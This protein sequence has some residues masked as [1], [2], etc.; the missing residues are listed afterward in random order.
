MQSVPANKLVFRNG[1][2]FAGKKKKN[3]LHRFAKQSPLNKNGK[4]NKR[5]GRVIRHASLHRI[6][7]TIDVSNSLREYTRYIK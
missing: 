2:N 5:M 4:I 7:I 1:F 6:F 3:E